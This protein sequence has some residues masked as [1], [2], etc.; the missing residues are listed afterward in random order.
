MEKEW[1]YAAGQSRDG[2]WR[3]GGSSPGNGCSTDS[4]GTLLS[5]GFLRPE[6]GGSQGQIGLASCFE[7]QGLLCHAFEPLNSSPTY[8]MMRPQ[9]LPGRLGQRRRPGQVAL[10]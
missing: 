8:Q 6:Q 7:I 3:P 5:F 10:L 4:T 2:V 1:L 9:V